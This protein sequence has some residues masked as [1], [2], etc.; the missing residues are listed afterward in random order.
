MIETG[1]LSLSLPPIGHCAIKKVRI[2][3]DHPSPRWPY[4]ICDV[5]WPWRPNKNARREGVL[6]SVEI[7]FSRSSSRQFKALAEAIVHRLQKAACL[8]NPILTMPQA[9]SAPRPA[10]KAR[11]HTFVLLGC[12]I[13]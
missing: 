13:A 8:G 11:G 7:R 9:Q 6:P 5:L 3:L 2:R 10:V 1:W 4:R 12:R